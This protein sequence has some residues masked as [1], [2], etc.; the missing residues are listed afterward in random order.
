MQYKFVDYISDINPTLGNLQPSKFG[1][2]GQHLISPESSKV[3]KNN[4]AFKVAGGYK[5]IGKF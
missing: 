3:I 5:Y 2:G 4:N 1:G